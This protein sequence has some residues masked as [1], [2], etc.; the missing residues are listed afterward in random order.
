MSS[1]ADKDGNIWMSTYGGGVWKY[2]GKVLSNI[3]VKN[4]DGDVLLISIFQDKEGT[5]WLGTDNDGIYK[6]DGATFEK[7]EPN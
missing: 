5:L 3:D 7:F 4:E 2:D 1:V 6:G